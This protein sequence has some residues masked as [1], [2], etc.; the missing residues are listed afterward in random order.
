MSDDEILDYLLMPEML[1]KSFPEEF[2]SEDNAD[3]SPF[4]ALN[5]RILILEADRNKSGRLIV[6][7]RKLYEE[8]SSFRDL[9]A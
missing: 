9:E 1:T 5:G 2:N 4:D 6:L 7:F 8:D 3:E